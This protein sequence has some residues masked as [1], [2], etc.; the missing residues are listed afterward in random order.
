MSR[1]STRLNAAKRDG[2][3]QAR[4][5]LP[6][7][8]PDYARV[9]ERG[10]AE[11]LTF[12]RA[13]ARELRFYDLDG[14]PTGDW[15]GLLETEGVS[16]E[17]IVAYL[18]D[19]TSASPA[20]AQWLSR[21]HLAVFLTFL[22]LLGHAREQLNGLTARHLDYYYEQVLG[23]RR[24]EASPDRVAVL[25]ELPPSVSRARL[26]AGTEFS[27]GEDASGQPRIYRSQADFYASAAQVA[28]LR[29]VYVDYDIV[30]LEALANDRDLSE[31]ERFT[32]MLE[33]A[34]GQPRPGD[35]VPKL[36]NR[37]VNVNYVAARQQRVDFAPEQLHLE[38]HELRTLM[39]LR[40]RRGDA[41]D[42]EWA[43]INALLG[44]EDPEDP[45]DFT[46]NLEAVAGELDYAGLPLVESIDDL[47][48]RR[49][50]EDCAAFIAAQLP[51]GRENFEALMRIKQRIDGE[52]AEL[53]R[54]LA[55][56][57]RRK[58]DALSFDLEAAVEDYDPTD[59]AANFAAALGEPEWPD[60]SADLDQY[61]ALVQE[62]EAHL[63][64]GA[65][66]ISRMA[67]IANRAKL[68][69]TTEADWARLAQLMREARRERVLASRR[70]EIASQRA[71]FS[72]QRA[73]ARS[74]SFALDI[75]IGEDDP[76]P[77]WSA[78]LSQAS[79]HLEDTQLE[80]LD[81]YH[82]QLGDADAAKLL[83]WSDAD[84]ILELCWRNRE[85][86]ELDAAERVSWRNLY[87]HE[88]V[89]ALTV[90]SG[91]DTPRWK[92][93]GQRRP[94]ASV[95]RVPAPVIGAALRSP[96]LEL[97]SGVRR[98]DLTMG[99]EVE[100]FDLAQIDAA[101]E[102]DALAVEV[103]TA[104]GWVELEFETFQ[105]GGG[106]PGEDYA[107]LIAGKRQPDE[108]RPAL[109]LELR[110][111]ER[112][113][114]F[115]PLADSGERW[116]SLRLMLRQHW[117]EASAS[118]RSH[119]DAFSGLHL[120]AVHLKVSVDGLQALRLRSDERKLDPAKPFE[121]FGRSPA[122]GAR[123]Y[124]SHPELARPRLDRLT[125]DI[126]WMGL[127]EDLLAH[128]HN[129]PQ[130]E[131]DDFSATLSM[132]DQHV[133]LGL[134]DAALFEAG[135][136]QPD[137]A[138]GTRKLEIDDLPKRVAAANSSLDYQARLDVGELADIRDEPRHF[139]LEL[140]P[141]DFGHGRYP[142][143]ASHKSRALAAA[144]ARGEP[145]AEDALA[146][147][148]VNA[149]YTPK[150][151]RLRAGY[152]ASF[153]LRFDGLPEL[154][155]S[156]EDS[157]LHIHPFGVCASPTLVETNIGPRGPR[158]LP[159]YPDAGELY[160]GLEGVSAPQRLSLLMQL[161]DG[162]ADPDRAAPSPRWSV[163]DGDRWRELD[164]GLISDGTQGL[165]G[166]GIVD[167]ELPAVAPSTRMPSDRYWLRVA[168][169][170][171]PD[172]ACDTLALHTQALEL[173]FEDR[174]NDPSHYDEPLPVDSVTR[175]V[176]PR[177]EIAALAQP[178]TSYA[179]RPPERAEHF[180]TRVSERL[181][182]KQ[183]AST[184]WDYEHLVLER[185]P[186]IFKAKC[187]RATNAP[188]GKGGVRV[189]VVPDIRKSLPRDPFSP[190][191][192]SSLL[193][194]IGDYLRGRAP[195][196]VRVE[197][198]NPRYIA[199]MVR[200]G[201]RFDEGVDERWA[202]RQLIDDL[203]RFLS[204][205]AYDEG[206]ELSIGAR[207]YANS[208]ID[209]VDRRDYIDFVAELKLFR[210]DDGQDFDIVP[211]LSSGSGEGYFVGCERDD[212]ILVAARD[213]QIDIIP[214]RYQQEAFTG[215]EHMKL[216]L[217]FIVG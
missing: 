144:I 162:S 203:N 118:Y 10:D 148:E 177:A 141:G 21:P 100:G 140:G 6:A 38:H 164:A 53:S 71:G 194:E 67:R 70:A 150:I 101:L 87:A 174:Q 109:S 33:L 54:L 208:I 153:E 199:V 29:A 154:G 185:F 183:R 96:L 184:P 193:A 107:T 9:D 214:E 210:S 11:L 187:L 74:T 176:Q 198:R 145:P 179:G 60:G 119:A 127:P 76:E 90:D 78:L 52:W 128:Y 131:L 34:L 30:D 115:A 180:H 156:G 151:K 209:F 189:V 57:G 49:Q 168:I 20:A 47:Y 83:G 130:T 62:L 89:T 110:A 36:R 129:Y 125:L 94:A 73:L 1:R 197:V 104:D 205:W 84:R 149:P 178:Y 95:E 77:E 81:R 85:G 56:A 42:E 117:D 86:L 204:P 88:D 14:A 108:D 8:A 136:D 35:P 192:P 173:S 186:A 18:D 111:D 23:L 55:R 167:L 65:E 113:A 216:E 138:L 116:P 15:R 43:R 58:R 22:R 79:E 92:T 201:V 190:K 161:A 69:T 46:A 82:A 39:N 91:A 97:R 24:R 102:N 98:I 166:A 207:I 5:R 120:C 195:D 51:F 45:R 80:L 31:P 155:T 169:D 32:A 124:L 206:A 27:A 132:I 16:L 44:V 200:L 41:A 159:H 146:E 181:R 2:A 61:F 213:H 25:V 191:A 59:F 4:R 12:A 68:Q 135:Q 211:D 66:R 75:D 7:L 13:H 106:G 72:G 93:F 172:A 212:E 105:S 112:V 163:L 37:V 160:I 63:A 165:L 99:F 121:P 217:D 50:R 196:H 202:A 48:E 142:V 157:L 170:R 158:L 139:V 134:L 123:L 126:E 103:S 171:Y 133:E 64:T 114:A 152:V 19:P 137:L 147:Y 188:G 122:A 175:L 40:A 215:L 26:P 28:D 182:H 17:Q 3:S 143:L